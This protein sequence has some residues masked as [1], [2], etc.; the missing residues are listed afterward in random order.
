MAGRVSIGGQEMDLQEA[1]DAVTERLETLGHA[2][3]ARSDHLNT[4][5]EETLRGHT[6]RPTFDM[7]GSI[8]PFDGEKPEAVLHFFES[9][10]NVV[11][12]RGRGQWSRRH[13]SPRVNEPQAQAKAT[14]R[15]ITTGKNT[16]EP[17]VGALVKSRETARVDKEIRIGPV[18]KDLAE[19]LV[20]MER[21]DNA[22]GKIL[23]DNGDQ[24]SLIKRGAAIAPM[25]K[26]DLI[27]RGIQD[28][29]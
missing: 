4:M 22:D 26:P 25:T 7:V 10:D 13:P 5:L 17:R 28:E 3:L 23:I 1:I 29:L 12:K 8:T 16:C 19:E 2:R 21:V 20:A 18:V 9:I 15:N 6:E 24:L 11:G 27:I 14:K